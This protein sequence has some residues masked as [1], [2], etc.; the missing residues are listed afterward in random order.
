MRTKIFLVAL[1]AMLVTSVLLAQQTSREDGPALRGQTTQPL[2]DGH[3]ERYTVRLGDTLWDISERFL[4]DPWLWPEIWYENPFIDN[5]HLIYPGDVVKLTTVD[6]QPRLT[7]ER[8][9]G[10]VKLSPRVRM[11][12]L[13][14]AITTIPI[15]AI[16]PFLSGNRV[17]GAET[18]DTAPYIVAGADER[19]MGSTGDPVYV[20]RLGDSAAQGYKVMRQGQPFIDP[21]SG[22]LLG[23][24]AV[25]V[26]DA[27]RVR[28]GDPATYVLTEI[29]REVLPGDVLLETEEDL[30]QSR[31]YPRPPEGEVSGQILAVLD[32]VTQVGQF[33]VVAINRGENHG[34]RQGDV[35]AVYKR[36]RTVQ[37]RFSADQETITL[38]DERA[39]EMIIF[40]TFERLS[41]GL[42]MEASRAMRVADLVRNP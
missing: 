40:R 16:R 17:V 30:I 32:G 1:C 19:V 38:P 13:D 11:E 34:L 26:G 39:G 6:G 35:L 8:G 23:Y 18:F 14:Q 25:Y 24:E 31:Y 9:G 10:T 33:D 2:R 41:L 22:E 29:N 36:G 37:D 42:I 28:T 4:R 3:P 27:A 21:E 15:D 7:V 5:P 20:R 12:D